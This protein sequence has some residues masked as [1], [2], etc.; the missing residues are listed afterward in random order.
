MLTVSHV[1]DALRQT[2]REKRN[3]LLAI[4]G[5]TFIFPFNGLIVNYEL[6][7]SDF[8]FK[9]LGTQQ[10]NQAD[11]VKFRSATRV[12]D[13]RGQSIGSIEGR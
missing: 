5:A 4:L 7:L 13:Q 10:M 1:R 2:F 9:L 3:I 12:L 6:L 11:V 8:S